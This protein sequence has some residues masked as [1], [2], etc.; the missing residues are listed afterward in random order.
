V[1]IASD[2]AGGLVVVW[3]DYRGGSHGAI[4]AQHVT[5]GGEVSWPVDG[6]AVSAGESDQAAPD[7]IPDGSGGAFVVW[8]DDRAGDYDLRWARLDA[9]G[10]VTPAVGGAPL[11]QA[12]ADQRAVRLVPSGA[13]HVTAVW[14][15]ADAA[16]TRLRAAR[17]AIEAVQ[18]ISEPSAGALLTPDTGPSTTTAIAGDGA[19]GAFVAWSM[20]QGSARD[21]RLQHINAQGGTAFGDTGLVVCGET[22]EQYAPALCP[23]GAGGCIVAWED[24]R[25]GAADLYAQRVSASG[26]LAW[27]ADG[28]PLSTAAG[29]QYGA[30]LRADGSGGVFATWTDDVLPARATFLRARTALPGV[31]PRL[32]SIEAGPGRVHLV[33]QGADTDPT[34]YQVQRRTDAEGWRSLRE[35]RLGTEGALELEDRGVLPGAHVVYRLAIEKQGVTVSLEETAID[36]PLPMPLTLRFVRTED[37]GR[38]I[39]I[40]YVLETH[41]RASLEILDVAGRRMLTRDLGSPGAGEHELRIASEPLPAGIYFTRLHQNQRVRTARLT[42]IR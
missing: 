6:V 30:A 34:T 26:T 13:T 33:W 21:I 1:A 4:Y 15:D 11:V 12:H 24:F 35:S 9:T 5:A 10:T 8:Q 23:D 29:Q 25:S 14:Q 19:S 18:A 2:G 42:L 22:H 40:N 27:A 16:A 20:L 36:I 28:A 3:Q 32:V 38:T 37:R 31:L 7:V 17:F 41:D 39:R